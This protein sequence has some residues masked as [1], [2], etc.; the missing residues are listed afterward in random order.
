MATSINATPRA[1]LN[2]LQDKSRRP[3]VPVP[4]QIPQHLPYIYTLAERGPTDPQLVDS[5]ARNTIYGAATW[6]QTSPFATHQTVIA[7]TMNARGNTQLVQRLKPTGANTA[8]LR[9]SAELIPTNI[10]IYARNPMDGS[11]QY[12]TQTPQQIAN[13][14]PPTPTISETIVGSRVVLYSTVDIY[15]PA[16]QGFGLGQVQAGSALSV[17]GGVAVSP[18]P[19]GFRA[20]TVT[21]SDGTLTPLG[22]VSYGTASP[23][24][25]ITPT[26]TLFPLFDLNVG[27][28]GSYGNGIG[29]RMQ[30]P[31]VDDAIPEDTATME[32]LRA[33]IYRF[34]CVENSVATGTPNVLATQL[35]DLYVDACLKPNLINPNTGAQI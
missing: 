4:Q 26:S 19:A 9:I 24:L 27:S 14:I 7:N 16:Q 33:Y 3:P 25:T 6:D 28:F 11:I 8:I 15:G 31:T 1:V 2:G 32:A 5:I 30:A 22:V 21:S 29:L 10:P 13:G 18:A 12:N 23:K 34:Y 17:V 35:G 20:G